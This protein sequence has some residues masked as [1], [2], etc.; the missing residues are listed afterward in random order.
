MS[1]DARAKAL[2][3]LAH[4]QVAASTVGDTLDRIA[5]IT[6]EALPSAAVAG[7]SV[8]GEDEQPTTAIY[9]DEE[10]PEID[11]AQYREGKGPCLDA[12]RYN[13][14][15]R[16]DRVEDWA[17]T[18]PGFVTACADHGVL[19]TLSLP[20]VSGGVAIGALNLYARAPDGFDAALA[21]DLAGAA[22]AQPPGL[23]TQSTTPIP[24]LL[25]AEGHLGVTV[26]STAL[27]PATSLRPTHSRWIDLA[28]R[29]LK[30]LTCLGTA[31]Y[32]NVF[33][34]AGQAG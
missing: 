18:Y 11:A 26:L 1:L 16:V 3:A 6:L 15:I 13:R 20:M 2:S 23:S 5:V 9:T 29:E 10:S 28:A 24:R 21:V 19:S 12:W 27:F 32:L 17:E 7:M 14:V 22:M 25:V 30:A 34:V 8:L 33:A 4:F 31:N